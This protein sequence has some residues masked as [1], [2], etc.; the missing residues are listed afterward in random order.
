MPRRFLQAKWLNLIMANYT[1][2]PDLLLPYLPDGTELDTWQDRHYVSLVGF[3]FDDTKVLGLKIPWHVRF[4]EVNLRF[5]VRR[6]DKRGVVFVREIVPK[7]AITLVANTLYQENYAT[8]P[9]RH[10]WERNGELSVRYEWKKQGQWNYLH[11]KAALEGSPLVPGSEAEFITE[12]YW[13]YTRKGPG[14][15]GEYRV[16]H[17]SWNIHPVHYFD[18]Q[19]DIAR[20]YGPQFVDIFAA[21]P[22]SVFLADGSEIEVYQD[23]AL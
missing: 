16:A 6:G 4:E 7:P 5:Y 17:P 13:G 14:K 8:M 19:I 22:I 12:H 1:V 15:T 3:L 10:H 21:E 18:Q 11:V 9:M 23:A 20:V 2:D